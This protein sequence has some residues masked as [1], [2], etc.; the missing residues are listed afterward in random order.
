M[1]AKEIALLLAAAVA[2]ALGAYIDTELGGVA[3]AMPFYLLALLVVNFNGRR[4]ITLLTAITVSVFTL[5]PPFLTVN[6]I[7]PL[8]VMWLSCIWLAT[9]ILIWDPRRSHLAIE[10]LREAFA[11]APTGFALLDLDGCVVM[12]NTTL[13][14]IIGRSGE[15]L[16]GQT[17]R[18]LVGTEVWQAIVDEFDVL[19]SGKSLEIEYTIERPDG[20]F[21]RVSGYSKIVCDTVG[22]PNYYLVQLLD[23][24]ERHA[25]EEARKGAESRFKNVI[26]YSADLILIVDKQG[27]IAH[28]NPRTQQ[29][30]GKDEATLLGTRATELFV[31]ADRA[32]F[33][34]MLVHST[35]NPER[36]Q[37]LEQLTLQAS[38][39]V[40]VD[41]RFVGLPLTPGI[42]GTV[43]TCR[44]ITDRI[45]SMRELRAS[46]ARFSRIF[47]ASPDAI[48]I[49][50][51]EDSTILDFNEGFSRLLGHSREAAIGQ[52][53][54]DLEFWIDEEQR[55]EVLRE[56][57]QHNEVIDRETQLRTADGRIVHVEISLRYIEIDGDI[58]ILCIGRDITKRIAAEA[59]L[60]DSE[61][62]FGSV[63]AY[64]PDGIV[65]LRQKDATIYDINQAFL[66]TSGFTREDLLDKSVAELPIFQDREEFLEAAHL[67]A[68][69][70]QYSNFEINFKTRDG[71]LIPAL[72]SATTFELSGESF[73]LCIAKDVRE[74]RTT[75]ERL[76][77]S[78]ARFRGAFENAP[79]GIIL[80]DLEGQIFQANRF[81][82]ELLAYDEKQMPG[83]HLSRLV[84]REDRQG[85]KDQLQRLVNPSGSEVSRIERRLVCHNGLEIWTNFHVVLQRGID[86]EPLYCIVQIADIT[87]TK[88]SQRRMERMAFYDTLTDLAN[89]RLF[90]D[91]LRQAIDHSERTQ[92]SAALLYLDLDQF[93]RVNDT[94]GHEAGDQLLREA[95]NRLTQCVRK[96]D[97]VA[98]PGGDEFT[99]LLYD[100]QSPSDAGQV[101]EKVLTAMREPMSVHG[102]KLVITTSIG[103][104]IIPADGTETNSLMK[105]AD[106]AMYR[107]KERGR[108]N[109]QF[110][111]ED[112]NTYAEHRLRTENE[113]RS[114]LEEDQF[115][116][117]YQPKVRLSDQRTVGVE[118]L[119]RWNHPDRGLLMPGEF[120]EI[121][122]E[123]GFIVEM[124]SWAIQTACVAA[125]ALADKHKAPLTMAIN[126]SPRQFRD[127]SLIN[128]IRR[129]IRKSRID[130]E[131]IEFEITETML[132]HDVD[133]ASETVHRLHD[134]GVRL[135]I[136]DFGTGYSSL[137]YLKKFPIDTVKIDRSFIMDIPHNTDDME[138]TAAVIAMAHRLNMDVV[139]EGVETAE[140]LEF[141]IKHDCEYAQGYL[142][143]K[144]QPLREIRQLIAPNVRMLRGE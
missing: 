60:K 71:E 32:T 65:I 44:V 49:V 40:H 94:L 87:D 58:C 53:E 123:T 8:R 70:G 55:L 46:E 54:S 35:E 100:V 98:R 52:E 57:Q 110:Y 132:M 64:S 106:L 138:I 120:V 75:E 80:I 140:Q 63:F 143:S 68:T 26:D 82:A 38:T 2:V 4:G 96:E 85:L 20:T 102:Q 97:T 101:A 118:A 117:Y 59:A 113:L 86:G 74:L 67:L 126:I 73:A 107:A 10:Q 56:L 91:R 135:A 45:Q 41:A 36:L 39:E 112:M 115:V 50:R 129:S 114:A 9:A 13:A 25:I 83:L 121:A 29:V 69:E 19:T 15:K 125:R 33:A 92:R 124:G 108:N 48:L 76:M 6:D 66:D 34:R 62:K 144:A 22:K 7:A 131:T 21:V 1:D 116:L 3:V 99:I 61:E 119:I 27:Y 88:L 90:Q 72:V 79:I 128:T 16:I 134:L 30:L 24:S 18:S 14:D 111:S 93:K 42:E 133:A 28:T 95:A 136:D 109:F 81:S 77:R 142:F 47:H 23:I 141:L 5:G 89:R 12:A 103:I 37:Q 78:E 137:N 127:P 11:Q 139:A 43:V 31:Q 105:N 130:P 122:E 104:T 84:P 17:L 51:R